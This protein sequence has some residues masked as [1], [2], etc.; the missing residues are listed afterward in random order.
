MWT[1][2]GTILCEYVGEVLTEEEAGEGVQSFSLDAGAR[3]KVDDDYLWECKDTVY[4]TGV[5][6]CVDAARYANEVRT[7]MRGCVRVTILLSSNG[8]LKTRDSHPAL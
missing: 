5:M 6:L 8:G 3:L 4:T 7:C 2:Q 1:L